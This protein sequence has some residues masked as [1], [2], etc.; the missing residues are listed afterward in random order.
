MANELVVIENNQ[1][2]I[3]TQDD[4]KELIQINLGSDDLTPGMLDRVKVPSGGMTIW[5]VPDP[6]APNGE[7]HENKLQGII[8]HSQVTRAYW[9]S[10]TPVPGTRPDC[11]SPDGKTGQGTPGG[12]CL[13]CP[14]AKFGTAK[15][16]TEPGQACKQKRLMAFLT[17]D[18]LLPIMLYVPS[19]SLTP[20]AKYLVDL[21]TRMRLPAYGVV[22]ELS[23]Q[24]KQ[25]A[26]GQEYSE[27]I[28]RPL[29]KIENM[30]MIREYVDM[31][32]PALQRAAVED[33][34]TAD[35]NGDTET[36]ATQAA[37]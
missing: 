17:K 14:L 31:I 8:L 3:A 16:G 37:A 23:L 11:F 1:F 12:A 34:V 10:D 21:A 32:K 25:N 22:T 6:S 4:I 9:T 30:Q 13:Q 7:R 2:A 18:N 28:F 20:A 5:T 29:G 24:K 27:I 36:V 33:I 15:S 19:K 35:T 26:K